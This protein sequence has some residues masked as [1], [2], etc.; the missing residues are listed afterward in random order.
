MVRQ[1]IINS[2]VPSIK[3]SLKY[4]N[5]ARELWS[6]LLERYGQASALE[7]YQLKKQL[8]GISQDNSSLVDY[9]EKMKN[10]WETLDGLDPIPLCSCG[11]IDQCTCSLLKKIIDRENTVKLIQFLMGLNGG[12]D[13]ASYKVPEHKN[14]VGYSGKSDGNLVTSEKYCDHCEKNGHTRAT[15]FGLNKCPHC[16]KF[17]HNPLNFFVIKEYPNDKG[18]GKSK[19]TNF[20]SGAP[21]TTTSAN[22]ASN[23]SKNTANVVN[24]IDVLNGIIISVVDQVLQMMSDQQPG[25]SSS[26]FA[27]IV[28]HS[29]VSSVH[30]SFVL[31]DWIVDTGASDHMTYDLDILTNV[32]TLKVPIKI[33]LPDGS[34]KLVHKICTVNLTDKIR[35]FNVFYIPDFKQNLMSVSKLIDHNAL[36]VV[37][38]SAAC[39]FQDLSSKHVVATEQRVAGLYRFYNKNSV[40]HRN[41]S[42]LVHQLLESRVPSEKNNKLCLA[43]V[44][45][46]LSLLHCRLG[47]HSVNRLKFVPGFKTEIKHDF[48]CE[49]CI[50]AKHHRLPFSICNKRVVACFDM[51]HI[52]VWGPYKVPSISGAKYF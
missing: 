8:E 27:C 11:K 18:K 37:F 20:K 48:S 44:T 17:G 24:V 33:G 30:N 38:N 22:T 42:N 5:S 50:L 40:I 9:Y 14:N 29:S 25:L 21:V 12:Y 16:N 10:L 26:Q 23:S 36:S 1:W 2:L 31:N 6:E 49:T 4:V 15:C 39:L 45:S 28:S 7:V 41:I 35:L 51:L 47:H 34:V 52:D 46:S 19:V 13:T 43:G 32:V 3:D